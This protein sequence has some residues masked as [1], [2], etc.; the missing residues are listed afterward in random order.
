MLQLN[1][2]SQPHLGPELPQLSLQVRPHSAAILQVRL[3]DKGGS[4][5]QVPPSLFASNSIIY[6]SSTEDYVASHTSAGVDLGGLES[7]LYL[8]WC[9]GDRE[10]RLQAEGC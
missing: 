5:W 9:N 3:A 4:R 8:A 6:R 1:I 10:D 7:A 2:S